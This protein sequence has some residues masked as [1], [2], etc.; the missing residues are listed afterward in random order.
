MSLVTRSV[1]ALWDDSQIKFH[2]YCNYLQQ[3]CAYLTSEYQDWETFALACIAKTKSL[4]PMKGEINLGWIARFLKNAW[5]TESLISEQPDDTELIRINNQWLPLQAYYVVYAASEATAYV[6]DGGCADGH[7]KVLK[8]ITAY[9]AHNG[10]PPW[11]CAYQGACGRDGKLLQPVNFPTGMALPSNLQRAGV[12]PIAMIATCLRAE[13]RNRVDTDYSR[14]RRRDGGRGRSFKYQYDPGPT[15]LFHF[16][17]KL[18]VKSNYKD[19]EIFITEASEADIVAFSKCLRLFVY[20][21]LTYLE[22]ILIRKCRKAEIRDIAE[23]YTQ[24]NRRAAKLI[25]RMKFYSQCV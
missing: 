11:N 21:S 19:V 15:G 7:H 25:E 22:I 9:F 13:H 20:W 18:R 16:L 24:Q 6:L 5:N 8:K 14:S 12:D 1:S 10:L 3:I 2:T 23:S 4:Q 17:Y